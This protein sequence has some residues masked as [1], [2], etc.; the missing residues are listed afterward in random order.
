MRFWQVCRCAVALLLAIVIA[1]LAGHAQ[2]P[3]KQLRIGLIPEMNVFKQMARYKPVAD[4]LS[5][6]TGAE[7]KMVILSRYGNILESFGK[8]EL[9]GAFFGSFTGALALRQLRLM[10]L[11]RPVNLDGESTYRGLLYVR[12]DSGIA[13]VGDM[14]GKKFAFVD[15][16][17]TAGYLFPLALLRKNGIDDFAAFFGEYFFSGSH[18]AAMDAVLNGKADI[19]A[20]KNT[21]YEFVRLNNPRI[22]RELLVLAT[23]APAPSNALCLRDD[24]D[25]ALLA[26]LRQALL[27][28]ERSARGKEVLEKL[29]ALHFIAT[30]REDYLPVFAMAKE[31]GIDLQ[32]YR[33]LNE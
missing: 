27:E 14:R 12:K 26:R 1:P 3:P 21:V 9:D 29:G 15:K 16:A 5:E 32:S 22:D 18:D 7:V 20:S 25:P 6:Q 4:Y 30:S 33:Y 10:P 23:S 11:A 31:A 13:G 2:A 24:L 19:G 17:T 8:G 28:M